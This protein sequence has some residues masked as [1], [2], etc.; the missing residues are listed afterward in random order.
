MIRP[1]GVDGE[2]GDGQ[3]GEEE[4]SGERNAVV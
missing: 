3:A 4:C 2:H 1:G